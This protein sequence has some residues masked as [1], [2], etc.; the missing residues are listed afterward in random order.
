M[1]NILRALNFLHKCFF[2]YINLYIKYLKIERRK[3]KCLGSTKEIVILMASASVPARL[4]TA[5]WTEF[6]LRTHNQL[7]LYKVL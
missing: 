7:K 6:S 5:I 2:I 4:L 3:I 1:I